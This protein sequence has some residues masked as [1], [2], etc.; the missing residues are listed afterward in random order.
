MKIAVFG[1]TGG[2][3]RQIVKQALESGFEV[4][5]FARD[6]SKIELKDPKLEIIEGD[7]LKPETVD[8]AVSGTNVALV[9]LGANT[10]ILAEGTKNIIESMKKHGTK[11]LVVESSYAFSG[12]EE[13]VARLKS[14]GMID[15]QIA[16]FQPILDDKAAQEK[17]TRESG[18]EYVVV[19]PLA[20]TDGEKTG[21]YQ[22]GEKLELEEASHISRAD[23]ADFMLKALKDDQWLGKTVDLAY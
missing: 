13:G 15:E 1:A 3:G 23:V 16:S 19:R 12:S 7:I 10:P 4:K 21:E 22:I 5:A 9:A 18:L 14:Q 8:R 20:L 11:R 6:R 2:T 17:E